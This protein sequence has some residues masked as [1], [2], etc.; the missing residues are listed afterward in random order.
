MG[1]RTAEPAHSEIL[2]QI[3]TKDEKVVQKRAGVGGCE[4]R[5]KRGNFG[6]LRMRGPGSESE[7]ETGKNG[8]FLQC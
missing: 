5:K 6:D 3:T 8:S 1:S 7:R 2:S 4:T